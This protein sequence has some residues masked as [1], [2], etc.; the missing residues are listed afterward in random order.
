MVGPHVAPTV[1]HRRRALGHQ[2]NYVQ[3]KHAKAFHR[4]IGFVKCEGFNEW[5]VVE[6]L[7]ELSDDVLMNT[8]CYNQRSVLCLGFMKIGIG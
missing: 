1:L 6:F 3:H 2:S 8:K 7:L 4:V 5:N